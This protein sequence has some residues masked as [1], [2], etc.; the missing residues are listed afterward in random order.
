MSYDP[1]L[2]VDDGLQLGV[3]SW[4][5]EGVICRF[6]GVLDVDLRQGFGAGWTRCRRAILGGC[7]ILLR[8]SCRRSGPLHFLAEV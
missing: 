3:V 6:L 1:R 4:S 8:G 7:R 5:A 2:V